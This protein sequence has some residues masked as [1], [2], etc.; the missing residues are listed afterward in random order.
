MSAFVQWLARKCLAERLA[1]SSCSDLYRA[2]QFVVLIVLVATT[3]ITAPTAK[4]AIAPDDVRA[5]VARVINIGRL[6]T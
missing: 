1:Q 6:Q 5:T 4:T 3:F 2:Q